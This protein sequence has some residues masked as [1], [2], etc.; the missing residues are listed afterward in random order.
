MIIQRMTLNVRFGT[1][2]QNIQMHI[3]EIKRYASPL[4]KHWRVCS[5]RYGLMARVILD[6]EFDDLASSEQ[7]WASWW[8]TPGASGFI[9]SIGANIVAGGMNE[10][11]N[12]EEQG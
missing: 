5:N 6:F 2:Q 10:I 1:E 8:A 4:L 11:L 12:I 9:A 7:F 3:D